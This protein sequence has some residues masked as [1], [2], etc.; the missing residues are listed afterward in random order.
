MAFYKIDIRGSEGYSFM[1]E[2]DVELRCENDIIDL[3]LDKNLFLDEE[4]ANYAVVDD[5]VTEYD[6]N[7]F[8]VI[9]N[10]SHGA[11]KFTNFRCT[12]ID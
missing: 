8:G 7:H 12:F 6:I 5:L 3:A 2:T 11:Q 1:I 9:F 10:A 4:D